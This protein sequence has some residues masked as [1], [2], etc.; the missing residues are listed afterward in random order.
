VHQVANTDATVLLTGETGTGKELVARAIH[1]ASRRKDRPLIKLN[2]AAL[3]TGLIESELFG[4]EKGAFTGALEKRL[5]RFALA[6]GGTIFLDEI[7]DIPH[8]VQVRLLRVLQEREFEPVGSP[9]TVRVDV[10]VIAATNRDLEKA[11]ADGT[12]R[13][14]LFYRLNVFP[15]RLPPLRERQEDVSLLAHYFV[16]KHAARLGKRIE[17]IAPATLQ[18]LRAYAWPGNIRELENVIERAVILSPATQLEVEPA[19][20][21]APAP[22]PTAGPE[23]VGGAAAMTMAE[24][25]RQHVL[26]ALAQTRWVIDGPRGAAKL[27]GLHPNTLRSR[28]KRLGLERPHETS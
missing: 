9:R 3:P 4:H 2:C 19:T 18:Q 7:G 13:A 21:R 15:I 10:R 24:H 6:D 28:M 16:D 26:A 5:G 14:D 22:A 1:H 27:L 8:D 11:V 23:R 20:L 25:E 17:V 12:F